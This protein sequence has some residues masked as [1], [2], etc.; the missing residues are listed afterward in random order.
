MIKDFFVL[1]DLLE[2]GKTVVEPRD[3]FVRLDNDLLEFF[4]EGLLRMVAASGVGMMGL[5][6]VVRGGVIRREV[7]LLGER[8]GKYWKLII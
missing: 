8:H 4:D 6:G 2:L 1:F 5:G 3:L 7:S